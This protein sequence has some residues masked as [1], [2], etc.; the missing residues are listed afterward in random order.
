MTTNADISLKSLLE[1]SLPLEQWQHAVQMFWSRKMGSSVCQWVVGSDGSNGIESLYPALDKR[2]AEI[3]P[4]S[5]FE[6]AEGTRAWPLDDANWLVCEGCRSTINEVAE[7]HWFQIR[8]QWH[9]RCRLDQAQQK[10]SFHHWFLSSVSHD[11]R[12]PLS[13]IISFLTLLEQSNADWHSQLPMAQQETHR[14]HRLINQILDFSRLQANRLELVP[15]P[16]N[17]LSWVGSVVS[18]WRE[19][20]QKKGLYFRLYLAENLP[21]AVELDGER[22]HQI[23]HNLISNSLKFTTQGSIELALLVEENPD[24]LIIEVTDTGPGIEPKQQQHLFDP[25]SQVNLQDQFLEGGVGLGLNIVQ[26]L[27]GLMKGRVEVVS[28]PGHGSVFRVTLPIRPTFDPIRSSYQQRETH[29]RALLIDDDSRRSA[30]LTHQLAYLGVEVLA[31]HSGPEA[32]FQL[33]QQPTLPD[34]IF[35]SS[36]LAGV[37]AEQTLTQ[38]SSQLDMTDDDVSARTFWLTPKAGQAHSHY[39]TLT[40]PA[41]L[42]EL[43]SA[44]TF[45]E[46]AEE[47]QSEIDKPLVLVVDDTDL[48]LQLTEIQ[49]QKLGVRVLTATSGKEALALLDNESVDLIFMDI[50][51]PEMDGYETTAHIRQ[52]QDL[53]RV[54][55]IALTANALFSDPAKC[56]EAGMDDYL[57]KPY[58][59]D[60]LHALVHRYLPSFKGSQKSDFSAQP[61]SASLIE[62]T[63]DSALVD[64]SKALTLVGGDEGILL[65]ILSPFIDDLPDTLAAMDE[66]HSNQDWATLKRRAHSLKGMLRTFGAIPLGEAAFALEKAA[67]QQAVEQVDQAWHDFTILY[68][69][70]L[71][72]LDNH[73]QAGAV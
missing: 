30:A 16:M 65:T 21:D 3:D 71:A 14:L 22:L 42:D 4:E 59:P 18:V 33:R 54:P 70:T 24:E 64:W 73:R 51:M 7:Q 37:S 62:D 47:N 46:E 6:L 48:N 32:L 1:S 55:I 8:S 58:R 67:G 45:T 49:L 19:R 57:S 12:S 23:V 27:A 72:Q 36:S 25:F 61:S 38:L 50:M 2:I 53:H 29:T 35:I 34:W 13:S 40:L 69:K 20:A 41:T 39:R 11:L 66:A 9:L 31:F 63:K 28:E 26:Q 44:L 17:L 60:Q 56:H 68:P 43:D 5:S 10:A 52:R 15:Q